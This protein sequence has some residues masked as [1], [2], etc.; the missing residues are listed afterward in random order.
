MEGKMLVLLFHSFEMNTFNT[1]IEKLKMI[2]KTY[3]IEW[4]E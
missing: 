3:K 2:S 4:N 1:R